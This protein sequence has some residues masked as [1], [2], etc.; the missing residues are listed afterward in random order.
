MSSSWCSA[1]SFED[2][3]EEEDYMS[4]N[5][6]AKCTSEVQ[7]IRPGM[8][9]S[10][11][12][13]RKI[14]LEKKKKEEKKAA[15]EKKKQQPSAKERLQ[16]GLERALEESNKGFA[17]LMKMGYKPGT[18]LGDKGEGRVEPIKVEIKS[19]RGGLGLKQMLMERKREKEQRY[20]ARMKKQ[21][22]EFDPNA[23]RER[24]RQEMLAKQL[25]ADLA[26]CQRVCY[27]LDTKEGRMEPMEWYF[28]PPHLLPTEE[29]END[30][31]T[32]EDAEA[33][34]NS[35]N[36]DTVDEKESENNE[37]WQVEVRVDVVT[38]YLRHAYH[39]CIWCGT[40]YEGDEDMA[41]HCPGTTKEEHDS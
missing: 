7:D 27:S 20:L 13:K 32:T 12:A 36:S 22:A 16:E 9:M 21:A 40:T 23:F 38:S 37:Y 18:S 33:R 8:P 19:D 3:E 30:T 15:L 39:Y 10:Y 5:F 14:Q 31:C 34:A 6:L 35:S 4:D 2:D 1:G 25:E 24:K 28:W 26:K 17:M 11:S 29:D 41:D